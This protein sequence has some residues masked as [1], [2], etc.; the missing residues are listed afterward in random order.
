MGPIFPRDFERTKLSRQSGMLPAFLA[1]T[2]QQNKQKAIWAFFAKGRTKPPI[3][4][5]P[6][7][8]MLNEIKKAVDQIKD[9]GGEVVFVRTPSSGVF[10]MGEQKGFP[11]EKYWEKIL[12]VTGCKGIHFQDYP[13]TDHYVCPELSHLSPSDAIEYTKHLART[14]QNEVGWKF[15]KSI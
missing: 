8:S 12:S 5:A 14:L 7:D 6:L 13:E 10:L 1:D 4:G 9:R 15:P 3:D 2:A 11:R